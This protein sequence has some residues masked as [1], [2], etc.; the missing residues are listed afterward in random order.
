MRVLLLAMQFERF[1]HSL[2]VAKYH[3]FCLLEWNSPRFLSTSDQCLIFQSRKKCFSWT[4]NV[5]PCQKSTKKPAKI[6]HECWESFCFLITVFLSLL[7]NFLIKLPVL[8]IWFCSILEIL[9]I[10]LMIYV[11][12]GF[13]KGFN[14]QLFVKLT[15]SLFKNAEVI[16]WI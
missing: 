14:R 8:L 15:N 7:T 13:A 5:A 3:H 10:Y 4:L 9:F 12:L 2:G 16:A 11:L 1:H 6:G